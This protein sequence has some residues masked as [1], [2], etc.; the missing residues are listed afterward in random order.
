MWHRHVRVATRTLW[1]Y[2]HTLSMLV[3]L[4]INF[5]FSP[6]ISCF[7]TNVTCNLRNV[8][9][10]KHSSIHR[11][12]LGSSAKIQPDT[13]ADSRFEPSQ[14]E[15]T[16]LCNDVS[17]WLD[18]NLESALLTLCNCQHAWCWGV[19]GLNASDW[20]IY[21]APVLERWG[22]TSLTPNPCHDGFTSLNVHSHFLPCINTDM[23]HMVEILPHERQGPI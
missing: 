6:H 1:C 16:L 17:H 20:V 9:L 3:Y 13:R 22:M 14:W 19:K 12:K 23:T 10:N 7:P 15:A 8:Y 21:L 5:T 11:G 2:S 18:T 4:G